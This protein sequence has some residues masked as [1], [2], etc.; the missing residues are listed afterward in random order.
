[1]D[2]VVLDME[3]GVLMR[4]A[5]LCFILPGFFPGPAGM[6]AS[7]W[8]ANDRILKCLECWEAAK[9]QPELQH[10]I[11]ESGLRKAAGTK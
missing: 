3:A 2:E 9:T 6:M 1:M 7:K 10:A 11:L 8:T 5:F 4:D